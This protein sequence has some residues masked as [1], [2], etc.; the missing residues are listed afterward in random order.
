MTLHQPSPAHRAVRPF[1]AVLTLV[2][3]VGS[4]LLTACGGGGSSIGTTST[5]TSAA[6]PG[7]SLAAGY[8]QAKWAAGMTVTYP[9]DCTMKVVATG[10]PNHALPAYDLRPATGSYTTVV[11]TT[12][13]GLALTLQPDPGTLNPISLLFNICPSAAATTTVTNM[14]TIGAMISGAALFNP[15]DGTGNP[16]MQQNVSYTFADAAGKT[17]TAAFLDNCNGHY[18]PAQNGNVYHY[19]GVS[20]CVTAQVDTAGGP[21]HL[22]GVALDGFPI[23]GGRDMQGQVITTAQLDACNGITSATPEFPAGVYHYVLP[24]GV[25]SAKSSLGCYRGA[26]S[27]QMVAQAQATGICT[28]VAAASRSPV[29]MAAR[30]ATRRAVARAS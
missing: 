12:P 5:T 4:C 27:A 19:H 7:N 22:I 18:T 8:K 10:L 30:Q 6:T 26:V 20:S 24:E 15:Y 1:L 23:Y 17:Q 3:A 25:T 11:A 2:A 28:T 9:S 14:G 13:D 21:S 29:L 16:A